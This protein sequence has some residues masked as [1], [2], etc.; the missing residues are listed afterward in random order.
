MLRACAMAA[1][2][3][4]ALTLG[5]PTA[6]L[7][8]L[9]LAATVL[10]LADPF[11]IHSVGFVLSCA[12]SVGDRRPR[13]A[14]RRVAAGAA[15]VAR[16]P[17]GHGR[18]AGRG[19]AD[20]GCGVRRRAARS[21]SPRTSLAA[22]LVGPLTLT[23]LGSGVVGGVVRM[24]VVGAVASFAPY[25]LVVRRDLD[26]PRRRDGSADRWAGRA[27]P[28][29][30][31]SAWAR[32]RGAACVGQ[33]GGVRAPSEPNPAWRYRL[34]DTVHDLTYRTLVM[35]ILNRTP[36]SFY[37]RGA[38]FGLDDLLRRAEVLAQDGADI[39]DVGGVKAGPGPEVDEAEELDRVIPTIEAL[40]ARIDVADLVRHLAGERARRSVQGRRGGRQ[41]HQRLRRPRLPRPSPPGTTRRSSRPTSASAREC[42]TP[43]RSTTT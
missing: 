7:R 35:G 20:V 30:E 8:A 15:L 40:H 3:M 37:D 36:D 16:E 34:G 31:W 14:D 5:R 6:G 33:H 22:P 13:P 42:P 41:R 23:G 10:L 18:R 19:G 43:I 39:L 9:A 4:L 29:G 2:S 24:P 11:L 26:R 17:G 1:C 12:A 38:T 28:G 21:R 27:G 25:V 32:S